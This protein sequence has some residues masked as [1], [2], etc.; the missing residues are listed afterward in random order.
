MFV[1]PMLFWSFLI[2]IIAIPM[3]V[4]LF[5]EAKRDWKKKRLESSQTN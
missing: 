4:F 2:G 1:G 5:I 3:I